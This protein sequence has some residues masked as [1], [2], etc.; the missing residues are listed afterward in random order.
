MVPRLLECFSPV[1]A[2]VKNHDGASAFSRA[3]D[4]SGFCHVARPARPIDGKCAFEPFLEPPPHH[5]DAPQS[6]P[7]RTAL[8]RAESDPP[9]HHAPP[10]PDAA[11]RVHHHDAT[12][13]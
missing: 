5:G 1:H 12:T 2:D 13:P 4:W 3:H 10:S 6:T 7:P 9:H 11:S 8:R